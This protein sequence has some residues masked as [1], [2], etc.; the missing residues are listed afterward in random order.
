MIELRLSNSGNV[1][2]EARE[3]A[4]LSL[5]E[6]ADRLGWNQGSLSKYE[7]SQT[8]LSLEVIEQIAKALGCSA[9]ELALRCLRE[10]FASLSRSTVEGKLTNDLIDA[11]ANKKGK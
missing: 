3:R 11:L 10:R 1:L 7:S 4:G 2:R 8:G 6:L 9:E 5:R